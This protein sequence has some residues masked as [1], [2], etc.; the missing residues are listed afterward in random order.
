MTQGLNYLPKTATANKCQEGKLNIF[1][2]STWLVAS[3]GFDVTSQFGSQSVPV[4]LL[5]GLKRT[6]CSKLALGVDDFLG[7][8]AVQSS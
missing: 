4:G 8:A 2:V 3:V 1:L 6:A 7:G 5:E